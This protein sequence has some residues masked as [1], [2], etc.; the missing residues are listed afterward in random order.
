MEEDTDIVEDMINN[1]EEHIKIYNEAFVDLEEI[2]SVKKLLQAY[3][4]DEK[5]INEMAKNI[6]S[7][8]RKLCEYLDITDKC[9]YYSSEN[10]KCCDDCIID[11]F[12]KKCE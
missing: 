10:K 2:K 12:R 11:Y 3:K 1:C 8:D 5:V 9:K 6:V 7:T 4:Q